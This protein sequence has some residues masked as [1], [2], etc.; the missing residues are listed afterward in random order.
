M[1]IGMAR[2]EELTDEQWLLIESLFPKP[3]IGLRGRPARETREVMNGVLWILRTGAP[4]QDLPE[5]FPPY[6]TCHR[7]FSAWVKSGVL[8]KA[9]KTLARHLSEY[10]DFGLDECFI[11]GSFVGA[12]KGALP[13]AK[14]SGA[15]V[16][17]SWQWQTAMVL[18]SPLTLTLLVRAKSGSSKKSSKAVL[19][20]KNRSD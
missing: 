8:E 13:L 19:P 9:L 10:G 6:Q 2:R 7:R 16:R 1:G 12:K 11:D 5:R 14:P 3:R 20:K 17:S 18:Q 4:W 15:R